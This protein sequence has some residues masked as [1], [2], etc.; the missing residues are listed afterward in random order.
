MLGAKP[1][2][3]VS[4]CHRRLL[5]AN[6]RLTGL[7]LPFYRARARPTLLPPLP[8]CLAQACLLICTVHA[9]LYVI[10]RTLTFDRAYRRSLTAPV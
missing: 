3:S 2:A 5:F 7:H 4:A 9:V 6:V 10:G 1:L 8:L